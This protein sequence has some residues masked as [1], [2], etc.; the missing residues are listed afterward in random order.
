M[1]NRKKKKTEKLIK[2]LKNLKAI[3]KDAQS[4]KKS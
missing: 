3:K 1:F 2:P 4:K